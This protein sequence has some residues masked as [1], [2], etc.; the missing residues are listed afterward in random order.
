MALSPEEV[1]GIRQAELARL[2]EEE[3]DR[4]QNAYPKG[5]T[6]RM[7]DAHGERLAR[8]REVRNLKK[9]IEEE[10]WTGRG[11]KRYVTSHGKELWLTPEQIKE[12][13]GRRRKRKRRRTP[14][15][16]VETPSLDS[17]LA[18]KILLYSVI[19]ALGVL[20][21]LQLVR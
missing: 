4:A 9:V 19:L 5:T 2:G 12:R 3:A 6:P 1:E 15:R 13:K 20:I 17:A 8:E 18:K 10:F 11:Y 7:E 14:R 21:G 16:A